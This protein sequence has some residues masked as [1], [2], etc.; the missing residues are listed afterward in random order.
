MHI[1][2]CLE[3]WSVYLMSIVNIHVVTALIP[4]IRFIAPMGKEFMGMR[5]MCNWLD[6][7]HM[8]HAEK[9]RIRHGCSNSVCP[10]TLVSFQ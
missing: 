9:G 5:S 4:L 3:S 1:S 2:L 10:K 8:W 7:Y 6:I